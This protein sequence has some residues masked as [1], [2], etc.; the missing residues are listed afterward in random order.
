MIACNT[1][2]DTTK[3]GKIICALPPPP[4]TI[5]KELLAREK[6]RVEASLL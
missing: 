6:Q 5:E 3:S 2:F 1:P 4:E